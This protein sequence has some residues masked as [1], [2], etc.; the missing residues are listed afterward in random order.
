MTSG[1]RR[2]CRQSMPLS[3]LWKILQYIL[4]PT[5][6]RNGPVSP[7]I[8]NNR[9]IE[10]FIRYSKK[11]QL[12]TFVAAPKPT[13]TMPTFT[14][15]TTPKQAT[16]LANSKQPP[17]VPMFPNPTRSVVPTPTTPQ[18]ILPLAPLPLSSSRV[19]LSPC[20]YFVTYSLSRVANPTS[21]LLSSLDLQPSNRLSLQHTLSRSLQQPQH[22]LQRNRN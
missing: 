13:F 5:S 18:I 14:G 2:A 15:S 19:I 3:I 16:P 21:P 22:S 17:S 10:T 4:R 20:S 8:L 9:L 11:N 12:P 1:A 7:P 6:W